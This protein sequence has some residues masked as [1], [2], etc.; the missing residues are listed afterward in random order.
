MSENVTNLDEYADNLD[1]FRDAFFDAYCEGLSDGT[2]KKLNSPETFYYATTH[3]VLSL[4]KKL[5]AP[6]AIL[7]QDKLT[8]KS[9]EVKTVID[10]ILTYLKA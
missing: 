10:V 8:D 1:R 7:R 6:D 2:V 3:A 9:Q 5:A 4:C